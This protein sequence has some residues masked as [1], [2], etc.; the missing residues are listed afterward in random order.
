MTRARRAGAPDLR[1]WLSLAALLSSAAAHGELTDDGARIQPAWRAAGADV[2]RGPSRFATD[3]EPIALDLRPHRTSAGGPCKR[4]A[5]LGPRGLSFRVGPTHVARGAQA[6]PSVAGLAEL[7]GCGDVPEH[8]RLKAD[9]GRGAIETIV[10]EGTTDLPAVASVLLERAGGVLPLAADPGTL[11]PTPTVDLRVARARTRLERDGFRVGAPITIRSGEDGKGSELATLEAGCHHVELF[12]EGTGESKQA[13]VDLDGALRREDGDVIVDDTSAAEDVRLEACVG[14]ESR[15]RVTFEGNPRSSRVLLLDASRPLPRHL[16]AAWPPDARARLGGVLLA[17]GVVNLPSEPVFL[18]RGAA[19]VTQ[20]PV[21]L[22][23]G[24]CYLAGASLERARP[25][26][27][28]LSLRAILGA[29]VSQ[30]E[31]GAREDS[32][33]VTFCAR[34][35]TRARIDVEAHGASAGWDLAL[36]RMVAGAWSSEP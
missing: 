24:A 6:V 28:G 32:A 20:I 34:D 3:D 27:Y 31:R 25:R 9:A 35:A 36:V 29:R 22:E 26:G 15:V 7:H 8:V 11:P 21:D 5:I 30:D 19:G 18:A 4:I 33:V 17:H 1:A 14:S 13:R 12:S 2:T 10:G 23:P 16:P